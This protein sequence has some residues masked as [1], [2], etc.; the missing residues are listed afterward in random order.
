[1]TYCFHICTC[2]CLVIIQ[3]TVM[4]CFPLFDRFY[5]LLTPFVIYLSIFRSNR[6]S[7]PVILFCGFVMD[8][9]SGGPFGLYLTTY[10]WLFIGLRWIITFLHVGDSLLLPFVVAAGVLIQ[11]F[12]FIGTIVMFKLGSWFSSTAIRTVA[13][14]FG[15][16]IFTGPIF[17]AF[18][19]YSHRRWDKWFKELFTKETVGR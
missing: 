19:N 5:D 14:Q 1:M 12:I 2:L 3:T 7:I 8:N 4:P 16:A 10:L 13:V 17:L 6:E 15:W 18:F 9:L 11:N